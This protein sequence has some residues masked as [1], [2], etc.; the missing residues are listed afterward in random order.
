MHIEIKKQP[1]KYMD[2]CTQ[3]DFDK[4][5][6]A[7]EGL[8]TLQGDIVKLK[9]RTDEYRLKTPP[10]RIIFKYCKKKKVII[11]T[12]IDTRGDVYKKG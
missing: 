8:R 10:F 12:K 6:N 5:D 2:K 1:E 11:I 7:I 9:G 4:L 3:S